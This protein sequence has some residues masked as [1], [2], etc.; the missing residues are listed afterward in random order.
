MKELMA[1]YKQLLNVTLPA[2]YTF[3]VRFNHCFNRIVLDWLF[4]DCWYNHLSRRQTAISQLSEEQLQQVIG[5]M[6]LWL[7]DQ[8]VLIADNQ[9]SLFHRSKKPVIHS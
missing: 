4:Q 5:R 9:A 1:T 8:Q 3:P 2:T 6:Q 7:Q